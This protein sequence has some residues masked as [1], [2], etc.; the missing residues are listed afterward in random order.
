[1]MDANAELPNALDVGNELSRYMA[2]IGNGEMDRD[3]IWSIM[4]RLTEARSETAADA[5]AVSV[6]AEI[7]L[8][9]LLQAIQDPASAASMNAP[10]T[11]AICVLLVRQAIDALQRTT[12]IPATNFTGTP[13]QLN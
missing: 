8:K 3:H 11:A 1:M 10:N 6:W 4:D 9:E 5:L 2:A 12:G 13:P 7:L